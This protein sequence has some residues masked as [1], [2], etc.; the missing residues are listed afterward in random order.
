MPTFRKDYDSFLYW[1]RNNT[2]SLPDQRFL[3]DPTF[4]ALLF[5]ILCCGAI[6][7]PPSLW[8]VTVLHELKRE[9]ILEQLKDLH[10]KGLRV[11]QNQRHPTFNTLVASL[12][13]HNC[14]EPDDEQVESLAFV[15]IA[16]RIA[17]RMGL[18][19]DGTAY[20]LDAVTSEMRRRVW[21]H[22]V[23]LDVQ[24]SSMNGMET[25]CGSTKHRL[26]V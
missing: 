17:Q 11:C 20:G 1:C 13:G 3:D 23:W 5:A 26:P 2:T 18:H 8:N 4:L 9:T 25:C 6:T 15:S 7:A 12:F 19:R 24:A 10:Q 14:V 22:V 21:W 16:V